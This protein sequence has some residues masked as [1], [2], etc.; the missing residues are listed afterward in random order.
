[1]SSNAKLGTPLARSDLLPWFPGLPGLTWPPWFT[2]LTRVPWFPGLPRVPW[3]AEPMW[4]AL[5]IDLLTSDD[6]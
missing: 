6:T 1:M 5:T 2:G 3:L 4:N